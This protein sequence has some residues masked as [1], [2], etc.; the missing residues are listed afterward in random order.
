MPRG[1]MACH[2]EGGMEEGTVEVRLGK[3]SLLGQGVGVFRVGKQPGGVP[4]AG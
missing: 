3:A 4:Q 2:G 1:A